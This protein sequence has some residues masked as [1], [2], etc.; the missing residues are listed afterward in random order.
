MGPYGGYPDLQGM[1]LVWLWDPNQCYRDTKSNDPF[2]YYPQF[3]G[4]MVLPD[5]V[6][7]GGIQYLVVGHSCLDW[8]GNNITSLTLPKHFKDY[9]PLLPNLETL[10]YNC[11]GR[12]PIVANGF[13]EQDYY[14]EHW[15][16]SLPNLKYLF[17]GP[18]VE[19]IHFKCWH[20][21]SLRVV[22]YYADSCDDRWDDPLGSIIAYRVRR[23][24]TPNIA[25]TQL[26][27]HLNHK[28]L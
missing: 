21:D 6:T 24:A 12:P 11:I 13:L 20:H 5:T 7:Y 3:I 14:F 15:E 4:N 19:H 1:P 16:Y 23:L 27:M 2:N 10:H 17:I 18:D 22:Y 26:I 8:V 25:S 9:L 28:G